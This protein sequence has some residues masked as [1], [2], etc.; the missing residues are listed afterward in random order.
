M[1]CCDQPQRHHEGNFL[2]ENEGRETMSQEG[3][4]TQQDLGGHKMEVELELG[5]LEKSASFR[6]YATGA[7][8]FNQS[9]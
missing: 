1:F 6:A 5:A 8:A 7:T 2:W 3:R 9:S 4:C